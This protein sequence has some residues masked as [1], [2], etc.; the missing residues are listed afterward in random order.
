MNS[1]LLPI[2]SLLFLLVSL[3]TGGSVLIGLVAFGLSLLSFLPIPPPAGDLG[4]KFGSFAERR[5]LPLVTLVSLAA[6]LFYTRIW[7]NGSFP[8]QPVVHDEFAYLFQAKTILAGK[9]CFPSPPLPVAFD[10]F[11]IMTE[12]VYASKYPPGHSLLLAPGVAAGAP[13]AMPLVASFFSLLLIGRLAR[14]VLGAAW[15]LLLLVLFAFSPAEIQIATTYLSQSSFLLMAL[16]FL[17]FLRRFA[18]RGERRN[19]LLAGA[20]L[21]FT[22]LVRPLNGLL[23]SGFAVVILLTRGE[24]RAQFRHPVRAG[25]LL[26]PIVLFGL[27]G[28]AYNRAVTGSATLTPW[29]LYAEVSQ[30]EDEFGFYKEEGP[31]EVREVGEGKRIYNERVLYP[32]RTRYTLPFAI[33]SLFS[34]RIPMSTW[35]AV[36]P[37][38]LL[39]LFPLLFMGEVRKRALLTLFFIILTHGGYLLYWFPWGKY[40]HEITPALILLPVLGAAG[41]VRRGG[42]EGEKRGIPI[43]ALLLVLLVL[44]QAGARLPFQAEFRKG[45][46]VYHGRFAALVE[47]KVPTP[48]ILF[49][50]Y[51]QGHNPDLDLVNNEPDLER[52]ERIF[53]Y[54]RGAAEN[55][56]LRETHFPG[57]EPYHYDEKRRRIRPGYGDS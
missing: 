33:R 42:G 55:R 3:L 31:L 9:A 18:D 45:K 46:S 32:N 51:G 16:L 41:I 17:F 6:V 4:G 43:A 34:V 52:A 38:A 29:E 19:L 48:S 22:F 23:L 56:A 7:S 54:D 14:P 11:H 27:G 30:P 53:V 15:A 49:I 8:F 57:R 25:L 10:A 21:G 37:A 35:E 2:G 13:W 5:F 44:A 39:F 40:Y 24:L 36:P 20:A 1:A 47:R 12:P 28:M 50:R 26:A